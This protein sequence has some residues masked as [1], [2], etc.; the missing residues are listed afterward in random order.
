LYSNAEAGIR[1]LPP[2]R[3]SSP[4]SPFER[5]FRVFKPEVSSLDSAITLLGCCASASELGN[6]QI[7]SRGR[8]TSSHIFSDR[9][10]DTNVDPDCVAARQFR[11]GTESSCGSC[12][13]IELPVR[14]D[15]IRNSLAT[16]DDD[17][18]GS[19]VFLISFRNIVTCPRRPGKGEILQCSRQYAPWRYPPVS[20]LRSALIKSARVAVIP[21]AEVSICPRNLLYFQSLIKSRFLPALGMTFRL[22]QR[23]NEPV[24]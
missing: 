1:C 16:Q 6:S 13:P 18:T 5:C 10:D 4:A 22:M 19:P 9:K 12:Q 2:P 21:R 24:H 20:C 7:M 11:R 15:S 8:S 14:C 3:I 17:Q 23:I